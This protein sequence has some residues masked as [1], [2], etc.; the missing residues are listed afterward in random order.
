MVVRKLPRP[1][2]AIINEVVV[3][4]GYPELPQIGSFQ[5]RFFTIKP[6]G[7]RPLARGNGRIVGRTCLEYG[8]LCSTG[9]LE[10]CR[11]GEVIA[12]ADAG[13]YDAAMSFDFARGGR[14]A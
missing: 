12:I 9:A 14:C 11:V 3:D 13:A 8:I 1:V 5:H 6:D 2:I 10:G 4:S 7:V